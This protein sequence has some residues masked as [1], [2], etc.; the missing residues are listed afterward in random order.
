MQD[1]PLIKDV[2]SQMRP[3]TRARCLKGGWQNGLKRLK[4][5]RTEFSA[6]W[7]CLIIH[8]MPTFYCL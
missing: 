4:Y 7:E 2:R 1:G 6:S 3:E 5:V 8:E